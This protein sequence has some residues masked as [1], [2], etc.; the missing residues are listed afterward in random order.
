VG[1]TV[2]LPWPL[3]FGG[4]QNQ[5]NSKWESRLA[6]RPPLKSNRRHGRRRR[7]RAGQ[8]A[9]LLGGGR[10]PELLRLRPPPPM[11]PRRAEDGAGAA[12]G[13]VAGEAAQVPPEVRPGVPGRPTLPRRSPLPPRL[14][15]AGDPPSDSDCCNHPSRPSSSSPLYCR[16][17]AS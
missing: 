4:R 3:P 10:H 5:T 14:D 11:A 17:N 16:P 1:P 8:G 12:A 9:P 7:R 15:P 6:G 2:T 13:D